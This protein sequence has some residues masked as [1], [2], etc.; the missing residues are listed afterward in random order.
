VLLHQIRHRSDEYGRRVQRVSTM[1]IETELAII[2]HRGEDLNKGTHLLSLLNVL[3]I[4]LIQ[5][6]NVIRGESNRDQYDIFVAH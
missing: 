4:Q 6:L 1:D 5:R 3:Q 2:S